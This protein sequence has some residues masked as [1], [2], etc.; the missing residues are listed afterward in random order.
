[1]TIFNFDEIVLNKYKIANK[2][3]SNLTF[4][5]YKKKC[6][7]QILLISE[8]YFSGISEKYIKFLLNNNEKILFFTIGQKFCLD[9]IISIIIYHE[10]NS[11][12]KN[13]YYI[14]CFGIH[15]K[16]R[17]FGYGKYTLDEFIEWIKSSNKSNKQKI[18][19]LKSI[20]S[21]YD[22]YLS[23]GFV[24]TNLISNK[25]F[26]KYEPELQNNDINILEYIITP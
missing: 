4:E 25:L 17:K 18:I 21:S 15:A 14:L 26:C 11:N 22:F 1:M 19:L 5:E 6:L 10:T 3:N 24:Q 2:N 16:F 7:E 9:D 23:Y 13:K 12:N 20:K 8:M